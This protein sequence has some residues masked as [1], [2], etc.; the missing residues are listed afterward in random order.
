MLRPTLYLTIWPLLEGRKEVEFPLGIYFF[1]QCSERRQFFNGVTMYFHIVTDAIS[2]T[3]FIRGN[4]NLPLF[5][6][7]SF[8]RP[9]QLGH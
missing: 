1:R 6:H 4:I 3:L 5:I 9:E 8:E 7:S 2:P